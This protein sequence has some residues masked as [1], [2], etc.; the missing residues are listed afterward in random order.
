[1]VMSKRVLLMIFSC[2]TISSLCAFDYLYSLF[3][4]KKT[5]RQEAVDT[6]LK[7][8]GCTGFW[9]NRL[10]NKNIPLEAITHAKVNLTTQDRNSLWEVNKLFP[11]NFTE[12]V[13][14][15]AKTIPEQ[16]ITPQILEEKAVEKT[17][18]T[19]QEKR[20]LL[21]KTRK[22]WNE[23][24]ANADEA[25]WEC[26][27]NNVS[28]DPA[29]CYWEYKDFDAIEKRRKAVMKK[30]R[31]NAGANNLYSYINKKST[32]RKQRAQEE[33]KWRDWLIKQEIGE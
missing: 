1:M 12:T 19:L 24:L 4:A 25:L 33:Q 18:N 31:P 7:D 32:E 29:A 17:L 23:A 28:R 21:T 6:V 22:R 8:Y 9:K 30:T 14:E 20:N 5:A 16:E 11:I 3:G 26:T 13:K 10:C 2:M 27:R 15:V